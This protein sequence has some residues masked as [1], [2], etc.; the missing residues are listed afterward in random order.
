MFSQLWEAI[1]MQKTRDMSSCCQ[2]AV[3]KWRKVLCVYKLGVGG[4]KQLFLC[5]TILVRTHRHEWLNHSGSTIAS[6]LDHNLQI[7]RHR[8][9][10]VHLT[11]YMLGERLHGEGHLLKRARVCVCVSTG[12]WNSAP[13]SL[14]YTRP[15]TRWGNKRK[16]WEKK[17]YC[18]VSVHVQGCFKCWDGSVPFSLNHTSPPRPQISSCTAVSSLS[19]LLPLR[20]IL[21]DA[22][23]Q[24]LMS[25][26]L[27]K[28]FFKQL[29]HSFYFIFHH[30]WLNSD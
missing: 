7:A 15:Q 14:T 3:V 22:K 18:S 12:C 26:N 9:S 2:W 23:D 24:K 16:R 5:L 19:L 20:K 27:L 29:L 30:Y 13:R 21:T 25:I 11:P 8:L 10:L 6:S 28:K 4:G 17:Q 1:S